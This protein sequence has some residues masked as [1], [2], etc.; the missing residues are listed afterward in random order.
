MCVSLLKGLLFTIARQK[1]QASVCVEEK[2]IK[3]QTQT[4]EGI[5]S[6]VMHSLANWAAFIFFAHKLSMEA[7]YISYCM[8]L[9]LQPARRAH[10]RLVFLRLYY[11]AAQK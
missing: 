11:V 9:S 5:I 10:T 6:R 2:Y 1:E 3:Q 8:P 7:R 4:G